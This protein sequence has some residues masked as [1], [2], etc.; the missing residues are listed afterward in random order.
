MPTEPRHHRRFQ[1]SLHFRKHHTSIRISYEAFLLEPRRRAVVRQNHD[2]LVLGPAFGT[3][4]GHV[5][6]IEH[7]HD[8]GLNRTRL[9]LYIAEKGGV[10]DMA[11]VAR[12]LPEGQAED[13]DSVLAHH[14]FVVKHRYIPEGFDKGAHFRHGLF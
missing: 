7:A 2:G 12:K 8:L 14:A 11:L 6:V 4:P 5:S 10:P 3:D 13:V 1:Q 9:G